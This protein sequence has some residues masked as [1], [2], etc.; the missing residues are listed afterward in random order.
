MD[1]NSDHKNGEAHNAFTM[2]TRFSSPGTCLS[3][4]DQETLQNDNTISFPQEIAP[5]PTHGEN[6]PPESKAVDEEAQPSDTA[7]CHSEDP[8]SNLP[9]QHIKRSIS[10]AV[11]RLNICVLFGGAILSSAAVGFL[12]FLWTG[13]SPG[14]DGQNA[15]YTWRYII[16]GSWLPQVITISTLALRVSTSAQAAICT[17]F[18]AALTLERRP[19]PLAKAAAI[20]TF[21]SLNTS[22]RALLWEMVG[23]KSVSHPLHPEAFLFILLAVA[24]VAI[25]FSSTIL[26]ADLQSSLVVGFPNQTEKN[27]NFEDEEIMFLAWSKPPADY[28]LFG[29]LPT[30][31]SAD[32]NPYGLSD[33]G[34]KRH[35]MLPFTK[36]R[37]TV[38]SY[39]GSSNVMSSRVACMP[40]VISGEIISVLNPTSNRRYGWMTGQ[41]MYKDS[42]ERA[43]L[44]A[45]DD[46]SS[47]NCSTIV[48]FKCGIPS[49]MYDSQPKAA[50]FCSPQAFDIRLASSNWTLQKDPWTSTATMFLVLSSNFD[51]DG[52]ALMNNQTTA[53]PE[54]RTLGEWQ[55]FDFGLSREINV[56]LCFNAINFMLSN[57]S[58]STKT[59]LVEPKM[60]YGFNASYTED[61]RKFL[62]AD[63]SVQRLE[64]RGVL[65]MDTIT[66]PSDYVVGAIGNAHM[67]PS[68]QL[69]SSMLE[70]DLVYPSAN[71]TIAGCDLCEADNIRISGIAGIARDYSRMFMDILTST[72]RAAVAI[73][74][75]YTML[76][77]SAHDQMLDFYSVSAPAEIVQTVTSTIPTSYKGLIT[78]VVLVL[79]NDLCILFLTALYIYH[80][81]YTM[82]GDFWHAVSQMV[83]STT[84]E[85]LDKGNMSKDCRTFEGF[86]VNKYVQLERS[87][88][89]GR[90]GV[91]EVGHIINAP[92]VLHWVSKVYR[93]TRDMVKRQTSGLSK[94]TQSKT[95]SSASAL[96]NEN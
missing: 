78:V 19:T 84:E 40:P 67:L 82:I 52:W 16:L 7:E 88:E 77:Q 9:R 25:Q 47:S 50:A 49:W 94:M 79:A 34:I 15:S 96:E 26:F 63:P 30:H 27:V 1:D 64:D 20:S 91:V 22:P 17:S 10:D 23:E 74:T 33:T 76:A 83:G 90:V 68:S 43:N 4:P 36:D 62:G 81:R 71:E 51:N 11:G 66:D 3:Q 32:P 12:I 37:T 65:I 2:D 72:N 70:F 54:S 87:A 14:T 35:A 29:E 60:R 56:T 41:I 5:A 38:R 48:P 92:S 6:S 8:E 69:S 13:G 86:E 89:S 58:L 21:R 73:Q 28:S 44:G 80:S 45:S 93:R 57:V 53:L 95:R 59:N 42:L 85:I 31:Y 61:I 55:S 39:R 75:I 18:V 46:C 24:N